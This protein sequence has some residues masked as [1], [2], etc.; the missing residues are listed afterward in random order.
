MPIHPIQKSLTIGGRTFT[1]EEIARF[2]S[3]TTGVILVGSN[4]TAGRGTNFRTE[5]GTDFQVGGGDTLTIMAIRVFNGGQAGNFNIAYSD[6]AVSIDSSSPG[7]NPVYYGGGTATIFA[8]G[9]SAS[10]SIS[11]MFLKFIVPSSKYPFMVSSAA[12]GTVVAYC[13][14]D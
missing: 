3:G 9:S 7:V 11:E 12:V 2:E 13:F 14:I 4:A 6:S 8:A 10:E 1:E 5:D